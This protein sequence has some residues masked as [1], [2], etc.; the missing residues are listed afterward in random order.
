MPIFFHFWIRRMRFSP[1]CWFFCR[2]KSFASGAVRQMLYFKLC[3]RSLKIVFFSAQTIFSSY[4]RHFSIY[5]CPRL[6][7]I[8]VSKVHL[9]ASRKFFSIW[10]RLFSG[11]LGKMFWKWTN[12]LKLVAKIV[13]I[14]VFCFL[15]WEFQL[16]E[17][18][19]GLTRRYCSS[20]H[21]NRFLS[22]IFRLIFS[23][24]VLKYI[25]VQLIGLHL[26][27]YKLFNSS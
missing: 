9:P 23:Q 6:L 22:Y 20:T 4:K 25:Y 8:A 10:V 26:S 16:C 3:D 11:F 7:K 19:T 24:E 17:A 12:F 18:C 27:I 15:K 13:I 1:R 2:S 14:K 21:K 5:R